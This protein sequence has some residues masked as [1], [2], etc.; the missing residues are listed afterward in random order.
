MSHFFWSMRQFG[1]KSLSFREQR[2]AFIQ[3][4]HQKG[5]RRWYDRWLGRMPPKAL[6]GN[7]RLYLIHGQPRL[8]FVIRYEFLQA[9]LESLA[10]YLSLTAVPRLEGVTAKTGLRPGS[11]P[12]WVD[13]YDNATRE[14]V[15]EH[16]RG[17]I[18]LFGYDFEG[19]AVPAGPRLMAD[20]SAAGRLIRSMS[21]ILRNA[22]MHTA[23]LS[24]P[25]IAI[26]T[27]RYYRPGETSY[28]ATSTNSVVARR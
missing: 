25:K 4:I 19:Q 6:D 18:A 7:Y 20:E 26:A 14:L 15:A 9:D 3:F 12:G 22:R 21:I 2:A 13:Y 28:T 17:E 8:D 16:S 1:V 24:H 11:V 23:T 27:G 10:D 5:P